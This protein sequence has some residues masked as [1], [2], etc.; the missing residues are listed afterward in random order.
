MTR[1]R[2]WR[3]SAQGTLVKLLNKGSLVV[4]PPK[5]GAGFRPCKTNRET[6]VE[7][8]A[9]KLD[10]VQHPAAREII[11]RGLQ[12]VSSESD[13]ISLLE[14]FRLLRSSKNAERLLTAL[15][16]ARSST[17]EPRTPDDVMQE[18]GIGEEG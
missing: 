7:F 1:K 11:E 6:I 9:K 13:A 4:T 10:D 3:R 8:I 14:T 15:R 2:L 16:R 18:L 12:E 5:R 17:I